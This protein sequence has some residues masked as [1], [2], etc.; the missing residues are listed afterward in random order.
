MLLL[1]LWLVSRHGAGEMRAMSG[2]GSTLRESSR[3]WGERGPHA[4]LVHFALR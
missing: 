1:L 2:V 4:A 3:H